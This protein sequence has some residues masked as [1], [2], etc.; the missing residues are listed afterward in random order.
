MN[1]V[2]YRTAYTAPGNIPGW[3]NKKI[4]GKCMIFTRT[5]DAQKKAPSASGT[6][7]FLSAPGLDSSKKSSS[8]WTTQ[9]RLLK[10]RSGQILL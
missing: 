5:P 7:T 2:P 6:Y 1:D 10:V 8:S 9:N 4:R 3:Q